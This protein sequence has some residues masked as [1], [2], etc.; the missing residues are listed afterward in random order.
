M[1]NINV[2]KCT[3]NNIII[4]CIFLQIGNMQDHFQFVLQSEVLGQCMPNKSEAISQENQ[5]MC[6]W[7]YIN[8]SYFKIIIIIN[9]PHAVN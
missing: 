3:Q 7:Q 9:Y 8:F 4:Y 1:N 6:Q 5:V 2:T